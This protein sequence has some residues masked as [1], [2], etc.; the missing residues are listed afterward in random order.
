MNLEIQ[1]QSLIVS[2][3]YG[4]FSSLIYNFIY[5][6]L[7]S[8][9]KVIKIITNLLYSFLIYSLFFNLLYL[10]NNGVVHIYFVLLF[11]MGFIIGNMK[12]KKIRKRS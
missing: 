8:K 5:P 3:I 10:I 6:V 7:Y 4:M 11:I 1:I 2:F 9:N 12:T